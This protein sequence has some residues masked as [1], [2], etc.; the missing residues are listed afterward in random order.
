[1]RPAS[2]DTLPGYR[3]CL[4]VTPAL[5]RVVSEL[6]DDYHCMKVTVH[7]DGEVA[8]AIEPDLM[9]APWTTCPGAA[10]VLEQTFT[11][12]ALKAFADRGEKR[13][14]CTHLHDLAVLAAAHAFDP[15]PLV[16]DILVSDPIEGRRR[17]ELRRDGRSVLSW[18]HAEGRIVEPAHLAHITLDN[19]R[20]WIDSLDPRQREPARLLRWGTMLANGRTIPMERQSDASQMR[21]GSCY[22]FQ[23]H[24]MNQAKRVGALRDF[25]SG[26]AHPL[27]QQVA[28]PTRQD[29]TRSSRI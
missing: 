24:R 10:A 14:N 9:R 20:P 25:S 26:T 19:M 12:V 27:D 23:P 16:Y 13:A 2:I 6:E 29:T 21:A 5:D 4:R 11:G 18:V 22:T 17:A 28:V 15:E 3:R 8:T 7:H 1:M